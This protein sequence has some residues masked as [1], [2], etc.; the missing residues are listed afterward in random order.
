MLMKY[1]DTRKPGL[2]LRMLGI[3][4]RVKMKD[5]CNHTPITYAVKEGHADVVGIFLRSKRVSPKARNGYKELLFHEAVKSGKCDIFQVFLDHGVPVNPRGGDGKRALHLAAD[6]RNYEMA[7]LLLQNGASTKIKDS[8]GKK[9]SRPPK[10]AV[11]APPE[12]VA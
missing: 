11:A 10:A 3:T 8:I 1:D 5:F 4:E 9:A 2:W 12:Y 6:T 7:R